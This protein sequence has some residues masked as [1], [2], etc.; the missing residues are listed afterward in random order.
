MTPL[1]GRISVDESYTDE[2]YIRLVVGGD[3]ISVR[4]NHAKSPPTTYV[5]VN[6]GLVKELK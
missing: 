3:V 5:W 4:V 1:N 6:Q 2:G